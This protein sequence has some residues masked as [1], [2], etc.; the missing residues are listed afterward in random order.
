MQSAGEIH[1]RGVKYILVVD[2]P[3]DLDRAIMVSD[4]AKFGIEELAV[5]KQPSTGQVS[6][7]EGM[8][9]KMAEDLHIDQLHRK[10]E[11]PET[12]EKI[13]DL[14]FRIKAL[15]MG[16]FPATIFLDDPAGN[17]WLERLPTDTGKKLKQLHY[18]RTPDQNNDIGIGLAQVSDS[19]EMTPNTTSDEDLGGIVDRSMYSLQTL[20]PGCMKPSMVNYHTMDIPHFKQVVISATNCSHCGYRTNDVTTGGAVPEK[21]KRIWLDVKQ[22]IDLHRDILK[23]ETCALRIPQ[24]EVEVVPGTMGGRFTTVEGLL[25]QIRDDLRKTAFDIGP[26]DEEEADSVPQAKKEIWRLFFSRLEKAINGEMEFTVI[27]E[28]PFANSYVQSLFD[29]DPDPQ[30]RWEEYE[31]TTEE[32]DELGLTDMKTRLGPDGQYVG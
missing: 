8:L 7:V 5:E 28:D 30:L 17:A 18:E 31:R 21:G 1:E 29:P 11:Q 4:T 13:S 15:I 10:T 25:T 2:S 23:S 24:C 9:Q 3:Q 19:N 20:C 22:P 32:E 27:L 26:D 14:I 16:S 12:Y 6:S